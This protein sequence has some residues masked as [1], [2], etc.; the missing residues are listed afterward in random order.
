MHLRV[1]STIVLFSMFFEAGCGGGAGASSVPPPSFEP[2]HSHIAPHGGV[3]T[4]VA[5]FHVEFVMNAASSRVVV[6]ILAADG[7]APKIIGAKDITLLVKR[8]AVEYFDSIMLSA[9]PDSTAPIGA[10][11]FEAPAG[12]LLNE[13]SFDAFLRISF[14]GQTYRPAFQVVPHRVQV[15]KC[16]MQ[17]HSKLYGVDGKCEICQMQLAEFQDGK[18][19]HSDHSPKHG[20]TFFMAA[21]N[22]H[23]IEGVLTSPTEFRIYLYDNFTR[24]LNANGYSGTVE[25]TRLDAQG[26][27]VGKPIATAL[28]PVPHETY[29][30][31]AIPSSIPLP[32]M[33]TARVVLHK[34]EKPALFNFSFKHVSVEP[35]PSRGK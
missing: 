1:I 4:S 18:I 30:G 11:R 3:I 21:D 14:A 25:F 13:K 27:D 12:T 22:W 15:F 29:L 2:A 32:L 19:A 5:D 6:Y 28:K 26:N 8:D 31:T 33:A 35:T 34:D 9:I 10:S 23:H 7:K 24:P 16:P 17:E 20:G